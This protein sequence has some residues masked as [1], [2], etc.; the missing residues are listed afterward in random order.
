MKSLFSALT[1]A[2]LMSVGA[3]HADVKSDCE[4]KALSKDGKPLA[5]A[6]KDAKVKKC[7]AD[8]G[9]AAA[10]ASAAAAGCEAKALDKNGKK[11]AG[12]AKNAFMKKC[13][14]DA[15]APAAEAKPAADV[16]PVA[17]KN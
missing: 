6:A 13:E 11:L 16:K 1:L 2:L 3:A 8:G 5:G 12:A 10:P 4:A 7:L 17:A 15:A 14:K 9:A